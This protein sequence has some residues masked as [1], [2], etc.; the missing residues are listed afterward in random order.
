M[1][2]LKIL[3]NM[4]INIKVNISV[5]ILVNKKENPLCEKTGKARRNGTK[6]RRPN[7]IDVLVPPPQKKAPMPSG[8]K[9]TRTKTHSPQKRTPRV[10]NNPKVTKENGITWF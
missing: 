1:S 2:P 4:S 7:E 3:V 5:N 9:T 6:M 8:R 10:N